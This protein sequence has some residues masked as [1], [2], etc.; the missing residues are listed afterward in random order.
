[1]KYD[2][3]I[4]KEGI[5]LDINNKNID[6]GRPFDFG[7]TSET[8]AKY[9]DIY[10]SEFYEKIIKR[11]LCVSGQSVLDV[12]TGTGVMPRNMYQYGAKWTGVDISKEQIEQ[13]KRLSKEQNADIDYLVS[14]LESVEFEEK[15]FDVITA[16]QCFWYFNHEVVA[17]KLC[18]ILRDGGKLLILYMAWLPF[19]DNIASMSEELVLK[20]NPDWS[21]KG[22]TKR[23]IEMPPIINRY[24]KTVD[25]EEYYLDVHFTRD[26]WHGRM[27]S[28]RGVGASLGESA[29]TLWENEH[30]KLLEKYAPEEFDVKH[31]AALAV[32]EKR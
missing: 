26:S 5:T 20:Y 4:R 8:Y 9:R 24:F 2:K 13:A 23:P 30:K 19:E 22:E 1:M 18:R 28:C 29:L 16:C 6:S 17:P 32:L 7:K 27:K 10:P 3:I 11:G 12:G 25:R 15:S 31:Y 14:D 21:G